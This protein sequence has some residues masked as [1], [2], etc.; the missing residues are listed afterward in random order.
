[1]TAMTFGTAGVGQISKT[2]NAGTNP[3]QN[4]SSTSNFSKI[5]Q[6]IQ[7]SNNIKDRSSVQ[8]FSDALSHLTKRSND[9]N[10]ILSQIQNGK[11]LSNSDILALQGMMM[12]FNR[13]LTTISKI[14][15]HAVGAVKTVVQT[16]V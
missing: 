16:Q 6:E 11:Q 13:D 12:N 5:F 15:E 14:V 7:G 10:G 1:M 4:R 2:Y 3:I 8:V 9:I